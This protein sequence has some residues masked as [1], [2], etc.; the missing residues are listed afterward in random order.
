MEQRDDRPPTQAKA[1]ELAEY[2]IMRAFLSSDPS[3]DTVA[4]PP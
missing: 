4:K 1:D 2:L 3:S